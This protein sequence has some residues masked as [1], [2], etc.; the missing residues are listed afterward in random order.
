MCTMHAV[1][2][3]Q[4]VSHQGCVTK[5]SE[6]PCPE[7]TQVRPRNVH[8]GANPVQK[9]LHGVRLHELGVSS[10]GGSDEVRNGM[11]GLC[12]SS[13]EDALSRLCQSIFVNKTSVSQHMSESRP[14]STSSSASSLESSSI[15]RPETIANAATWIPLHSIYTD[16]NTSHPAPRVSRIRYTGHGRYIG[17]SLGGASQYMPP[18][19]FGT[20]AS[21]IAQAKGVCVLSG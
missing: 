6:I 16:R 20:L 1:G 21:V 4:P 19:F 11:S 10:F 9:R 8:R 14:S 5:C 12:R 15:R 17:N 3:C 18:H 13:V 2:L 7:P